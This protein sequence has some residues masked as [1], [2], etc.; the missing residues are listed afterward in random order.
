MAQIQAPA[1]LGGG[2]ALWFLSAVGADGK[3]ARD[4]DGYPYWQRNILYF[5]AK[6]AAH[7]K[8][9]STTCLSGSNPQ[10]DDY[11]PHKMLLRV[12]IDNPPVTD[13]LPDP[14]KPIPP[15]AAPEE[16][17]TEAQVANYLQAPQ[18]LDTSA[19]QALDGVEEVRIVTAGLLWFKV[20]PAPGAPGAGRQ[21]DLRASAVKEAS[22]VLSLG[23][24]SLFNHTTTLKNV[25]SLFPNN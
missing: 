16:L 14:G 7:D 13:P 17:L 1:A 20:T 19:I 11:C 10:G 3:F 4:E 21:V 18:G 23:K 6:P 25:F 22:K 15:G 2:D 5:I 12:V 9:Y 8:L 24:T